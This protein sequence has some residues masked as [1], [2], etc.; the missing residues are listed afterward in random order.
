MRRPFIMILHLKP[1]EKGRLM[2]MNYLHELPMGFG[3]ALLQNR[4]AA[5]YFDSLSREQQQQL[6]DKTH[7]IGSKQEMQA[8]V[9]TLKI[10]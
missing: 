4:A 1:Q 10:E 8:F 5:S 6:I 9:D 3:M 7:S 2:N